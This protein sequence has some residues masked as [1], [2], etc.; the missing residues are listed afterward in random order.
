MRRIFLSVVLAAAVAS[1]PAR[2]APSEGTKPHWTY[3]GHEGPEH[4]GD[5]DPAFSACKTGNEQSPIDIT[6]PAAE[7][8]PAIQ[9]S[10]KASPLAI[11]DNGHTVQVN[12]GPGSSIDVGGHRYE[13]KQFHFHHPSENKLHGKASALEIHFV[14]ADA[15]GKLAVVGVL[16]DEGAANPA[17]Q[18]LWD[19]IPKTKGRES[20]VAGVNVNAAELLPA[21]HGYYNFPGSL[22]TPPCSEGVSWFLL[23]AGDHASGEQIAAFAKLYPLNARPVQPLHGRTIRESQ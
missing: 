11:V 5:L 19:N 2:T 23:K 7:H 15:D 1:L 17:L 14:H 13:L 12:Y 3:R 9:F 16:V 10:Y 20:K 18:T 8:L 6:K 22:T 21:T 4:W